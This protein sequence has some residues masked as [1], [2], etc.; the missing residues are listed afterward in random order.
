MVALR[1]A[2]P[3]TE[4][5]PG[6]LLR[7]P[8]KYCPRSARTSSTFAG[9][10]FRGLSLS[11]F[12]GVLEI[13]ALEA[14]VLEHLELAVSVGLPCHLLSIWWDDALQGAGSETTDTLP[15]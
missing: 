9:S 14:P 3:R 11:V 15:V 4:R 1:D 2:G 5:A 12:Q 13:R 6:R 7:R 8:R 10:G